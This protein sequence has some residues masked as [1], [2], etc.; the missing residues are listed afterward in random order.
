MQK[1]FPANSPKYM[2]SESKKIAK[3]L[4]RFIDIKPEAR[5]LFFYLDDFDHKASQLYR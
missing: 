1:T 5:G 3:K 2:E 4:A